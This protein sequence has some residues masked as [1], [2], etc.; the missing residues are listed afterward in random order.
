MSSSVPILMMMTSNHNRCGRI[1]CFQNAFV[2]T[3]VIQHW[4]TAKWSQHSP[5]GP[6]DITSTAIQAATAADTEDGAE[7]EYPEEPAEEEAEEQEQEQEEEP[8]PIPS[9]DDEGYRDL[10]PE[11]PRGPPMTLDAPPV[12]RLGDDPP[13]HWHLLLLRCATSRISC[14]NK[15]SKE[16]KSTQLH[17]AAPST[18]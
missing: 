6:F 5:P 1:V 9:Q 11:R 4:S 12:T 15:A 7:E 3:W 18:S 8:G 16:T 17:V 2:I 10:P 14:R 13:H